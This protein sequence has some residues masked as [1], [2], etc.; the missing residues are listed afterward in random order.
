MHVCLY[1]FRDYITVKALSEVKLVPKEK[2]VVNTLLR[3]GVLIVVTV[4]NE[5]LARDFRSHRL[6][7]R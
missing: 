1:G 3:R 4:P 7:I 5:C 6:S 2:F